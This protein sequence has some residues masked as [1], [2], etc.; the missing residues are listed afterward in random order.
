MEEK[1]VDA[2]TQTS[3]S[4]EQI[5]EKLI[6]SPTPETYPAQIGHWTDFFTFSNP[7]RNPI[8]CNICTTQF[9]SQTSAYSH[10]QQT[11]LGMRFPCHYCNY[12]ATTSYR[13]KM[14]IKT[15]HLNEQSL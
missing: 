15:Q 7:H 14:H 13:R 4:P 11:H 10:H 12:M 6:T 1:N 5:T 3:V 8:I 2:K 9:K